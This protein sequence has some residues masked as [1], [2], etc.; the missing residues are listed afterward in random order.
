MGEN[1]R[2]WAGSLREMRATRL[3][4]QIQ[5]ILRENGL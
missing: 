5:R 2:D 3:A 1:E 4:Q